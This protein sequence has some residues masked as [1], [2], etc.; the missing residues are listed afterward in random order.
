[1]IIE[2]EKLLQSF[3]EAT[4][5]ELCGSPTPQGAD[6]HHLMTRG[7][8]RVDIPGNLASLDRCCHMTVHA[9]DQI[10]SELKQI[11]AKREG[12]PWDVI[13]E[14]VWFFRRLPRDPTDEQIAKQL[15]GVDE[16]FRKLVR[17]ALE[18]MGRWQS[19]ERSA[20]K[21]AKI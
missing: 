5:C 3:R 15:E 21:S 6:P 14:S 1:M 18:E 2:N 13:E 9:K 4:R 19:S 11:V 10:A 20:A 8:G 7:A 16:P 17:K 12:V